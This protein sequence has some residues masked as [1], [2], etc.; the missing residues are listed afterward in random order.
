MSTCCPFHK[1]GGAQHL[2]CGGDARDET[3]SLAVHH[4]QA[5]IVHL[6]AA[7]DH[8]KAAGAV[9]TVDR[10]RKALTSAGGA[11]RHAHHAPYRNARRGQ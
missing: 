7:R 6:K 10:V 8:L 2:S 4:V 1:S 5:A 11:L 9:R 3:H